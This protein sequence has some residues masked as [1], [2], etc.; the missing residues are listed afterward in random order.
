MVKEYN[1]TKC[2]EC[3]ID[4]YMYP[5]NNKV[6]GYICPECGGSLVKKLRRLCIDQKI[7]EKSLAVQIPAS[8]SIN[9]P[10]GDFF[11]FGNVEFFRKQ[12]EEQQK[13][14]IYQRDSTKN[15]IQEINKILDE[16][17]KNPNHDIEIVHQDA[18]EAIIN[19][20]ERICA[21]YSIDIGDIIDK[22]DKVEK[23]YA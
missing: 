15:A 8:S 2:K 11:T 5:W 6:D 1:V 3:E 21:I 20:L 4:V 22:Y 16:C 10:S 23:Y 12:F 9:P 17:I 13:I 19:F 18:D 14:M 7:A